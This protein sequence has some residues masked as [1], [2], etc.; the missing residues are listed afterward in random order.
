M[1]ITLDHNCIIHLENKTA[2]G[3]KIQEIVTNAENHCFVVNMG[4]SEMRKKGVL[5]DHYEKFE[6]L[7]KS[8]GIEHLPRLDPIE[9][10]DV[11]FWDRCVWAD[12]M[13]KLSDEIE[14]VLFPNPSKVDVATEG[15]DS[16]D[17]KKWLNRQCDVQ[18]M[19][20]H[21]HYGNQVFLTADENFTKQTKW[22]GLHRLGAG[23]IW[24]LKLDENDICKVIKYEE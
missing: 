11:T 6:E 10:W 16:P 18:T 3:Q 1:K 8:A 15:L 23:R 12:E 24:L 13:E 7:L 19:W 17:G 22:P 2:C 14:S 4:A 21:I 5:P 20:C 9:I